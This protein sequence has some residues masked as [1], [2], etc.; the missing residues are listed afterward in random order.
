MRGKAGMFCRLQPISPS[1][2]AG[3]SGWWDASDSSTLFDAT[4]G[5]SQVSADGSVAR[6]QDKSGSGR[7]WTQSNNSIR[8]TRKTSIRNGLD[9]VRFSSSMMASSSFSIGNLLAATQHTVFAVAVASSAASDSSLSQE[10][11]AIIQDDPAIGATGFFAFR[12][13][14]AVG[15][16]G[17][18]EDG[19]TQSVKSYSIGD[20][21]CFTSRYSSSA[22]IIYVNGASGTA[23]ASIGSFGFLDGVSAQIGGGYSGY[24]DGDLAELITY[25]V[26]LST[27]DREA[28]ESY[29]ITKWAIT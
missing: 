26:A 28:V 22:I 1:M 11:A 10:N 16:Y 14:N 2:I 15:S 17:Y 4:S 12:S 5:G 7:N 24:F 27:G 20:W 8:P 23:S 6:W 29:L 25:N 13:S 18:G 19:H 9:V 3:I 21:A